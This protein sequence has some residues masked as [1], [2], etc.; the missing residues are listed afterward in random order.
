[1]IESFKVF[2]ICLNLPFIQM[3]TV[4]N[5]HELLQKVVCDIENNFTSICLYGVYNNMTNK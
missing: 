2:I 3:K 4:Q 5:E 1:M